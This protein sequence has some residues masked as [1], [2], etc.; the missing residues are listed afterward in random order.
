MSSL[1][2]SFIT[3]IDMGSDLERSLSLYVDFRAA[4]PNL[5]LVLDCLVHCV[6]RLAMRAHAVVTRGAKAQRRP[7][8]HTK[9]TGA[10]VKAC[11]AYCHITIPS[12]TGTLPITQ[13]TRMRWTRM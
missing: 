6:L 3:T 5:D 2:T 10:F 8:G 11:L 1:L 13:K 4:F 7:V 9:K 12:L